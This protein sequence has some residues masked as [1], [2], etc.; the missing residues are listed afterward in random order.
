MK[1]YFE[2]SSSGPNVL[3][4]NGSGTTLESAAPIIDSIREFASVL[5]HDQ[6]GLGKT[7]IIDGP[8]TVAQ[9]ARDAADLLD[10]VGWPTCIIVGISFGGMVAQEF[11]VTWPERAEKLLLLCTSAGG[12][13]GSSYPLH[14][15]AT[16]TPEERIA[17]GRTLYDTRFSDEFLAGDPL[18]AAIARML[19]ERERLPKSAEQRRGEGMQLEARRGHDVADRLGRITC[20][21]LVMAGRFDGIAPVANGRAIADR[22][23][24]AELRLYEGGH[25][26]IIQD[27]QAMIDVR[28]FVT[29]GAS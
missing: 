17:L 28:G 14:E 16:R 13:V 12:P 21:T 23:P 5:A 20:P 22:V 4:L 7:G 6:R 11:A 9:Y 10:H 25:L 15:L 24:H 26:F 29:A 18:S 19:S 3:F 2:K 8:Y 1:L 27:K